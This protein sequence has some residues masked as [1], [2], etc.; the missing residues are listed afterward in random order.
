MSSGPACGSESIAARASTGVAT[1]PWTSP[2]S[3]EPRRRR[4]AF[5]RGSGR[6]RGELSARW[7]DD[8]QTKGPDLTW[9]PGSRRVPYW[10]SCS[11]SN[12]SIT[13]SVSIA[14]VSP[15]TS[16]SMLQFCPR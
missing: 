2:K 15:G 10:R 11:A 14:P 4:S 16:T 12:R 8:R 1:C 7:T 9:D 3:S 13:T 6:D 5:L